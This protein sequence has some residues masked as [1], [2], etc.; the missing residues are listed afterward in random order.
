[1]KGN[2]MATHLKLFQQLVVVFCAILTV[3]LF[4]TVG[5]AQVNERDLIVERKLLC[6]AKAQKNGQDYSWADVCY[7]DSTSG[8]AGENS[9]QQN[10]LESASGEESQE[11]ASEQY[12]Q[13]PK[14]IKT[15]FDV[16]TGYR[17]DN[18]QWSIAG[19]SDGTSPNILS[20]LTWDDLQSV[21]IKGK[22]EALVADHFVF[23]GSA[24][25]ARIFSGD[26]QDSDYLSDNRTD[27]FSRSNNAS[28]K[29]NMNDYSVGLGY[30]FNFEEFVGL[31]IV[32]HL[33]LTPLAGYSYNAQNLR[34]TDGNQTLE[35]FWSIPLG[36]FAGLNSKYETQWK[37]PWVG[38]EFATT[39]E[40]LTGSLR[41]E[42]HWADY[43]AEADWNL[44]SDFAHP[45]SYEHE[46]D[47]DGYVI[48]A[49]LGYQL[50]EFWTAMVA[51][52]YSKYQTDHG[53]DR[54]FYS[55][56]TTAETRLNVVDWDSLSINA[57]LRYQF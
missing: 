13:T 9:S 28:D 42:Y 50:D 38:A 10:F 56:G 27:E 30:R 1:M 24:A 55:D 54:T 36:P 2:S 49:G 21:Q 16:S 6:A 35:S 8:A 32:D 29:G 14:F 41:F 18:L 12:D 33:S 19:Q 26:N 7:S 48:T 3:L 5:F 57:G 23:E 53:V 34:M 4:S 25:Y 17:L 51:V 22:G 39:V 52:D 11:S 15:K 46:T 43:Y 31:G 47:G 20:E 40:K 45:K 37:G 44:R